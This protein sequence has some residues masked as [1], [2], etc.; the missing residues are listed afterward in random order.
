MSEKTF[1]F[2]GAS[3]VPFCARMV[4]KGQG[5]G[6]WDGEKWAMTHAGERPMVEFYDRRHS[7]S[8][9]G[10]FVSR[11]YLETVEEAESRGSG[12][13]LDTGS[14][15]WHLSG[16]DLS[17]ALGA[18]KSAQSTHDGQQEQS[19]VVESAPRPRGA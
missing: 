18:L 4:K 5:Y 11:Y 3:G 2:T 1:E 12:L 15:D 6:R 16:A 8:P 9:N 7:H 13:L 14:S 17:S 10:Q 19:G